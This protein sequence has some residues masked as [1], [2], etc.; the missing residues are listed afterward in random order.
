VHAG[1][2]FR[3][4]FYNFINTRKT[5]GR[6][7]EKIW[8]G[9]ELRYVNIVQYRSSGFEVRILNINYIALAVQKNYI[10]HL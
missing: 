1:K 3:Y 7:G 5:A 8:Y 6:R 10:P 4:D 2:L 9:Q